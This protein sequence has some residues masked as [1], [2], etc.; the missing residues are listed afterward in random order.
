MVDEPNS[1]IYFYLLNGR[2]YKETSVRWFSDELTDSTFVTKSATYNFFNWIQKRN[3]T[4]FNR[5]FP[6]TKCMMVSIQ[7]HMA[8]ERWKQPFV[9]I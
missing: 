3:S 5:I 2:Q 9:I 6:L 4:Q 7:Q 8:L 1:Q